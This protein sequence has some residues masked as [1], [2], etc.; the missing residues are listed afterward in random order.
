MKTIFVM[1]FVVMSFLKVTAQ[2]DYP[3][4][5]G[6]WKDAGGNATMIHQEGGKVWYDMNNELFDHHAD[7]KFTKNNT[8]RFTQTRKNKKTNCITYVKLTCV[9]NAEADEM[10]ITAEN[11][12]SNCDLKAGQ[13]TTV[14]SYKQE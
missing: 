1:S 13:T 14:K 10:T 7:G 3:D 5:S 2:T 9:L 8:I 4:I 6:V 11:M 12:D